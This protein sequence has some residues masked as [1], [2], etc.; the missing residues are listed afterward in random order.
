[1][2]QACPHC[3]RCEDLPAIPQGPGTL[4]VRSPASHIT[5]KLMGYLQHKE[6]HVSHNNGMIRVQ[7][8]AGDMS[9]LVLPLLDLLNE[10]EQSDV[11]VIFE[12]TGKAMCIADYFG[13]CSLLEF[14]S[15]L[16]S[17]WLTD[18]LGR[19]ALTAVFQPIVSTTSGNL[20]GYE[21][22]L[23]ADQDGAM[24][25]P[26]QMFGVARNAGMLFQLDQ[27]ARQTAIQQAMLHNIAAQVFINFTPTTIYDPVFC[28]RST[29]QTMEELGMR[30]DQV[31]FEVIESADT[32]NPAHLRNICDYYRASGFHVA[33]DDIG[34]GYSSLNLIHELRPDYIK[35]DMKLIQNVDTDP[36]K[37]LIVRKLLET[38]G[39][40]GIKTVVEGVETVGQLDWVREHGADYAQGYFIARPSSPP[41]DLRC[42][43]TASY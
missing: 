9:P 26:N 25:F 31:V 19:N 28:L 8:P 1:M 7:M 24:V 37:A 42:A 20:H 4:Y 5:G 23:R 14:G 43:F 18:I 39:E 21:C 16:Q 40:L 27:R 13:A 29:V 2:V 32:G 38:A 33:L 34:S 6:Q 15:R 3:T 11:R 10:V 12:P 17:K 35:L 22:L 36:Y 41:P 30:A